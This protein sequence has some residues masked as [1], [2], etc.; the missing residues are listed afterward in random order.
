MTDGKRSFDVGDVLRMPHYPTVG[1]GRFRVWTVEGVHLGGTH[2]EGTYELRPIDILPNETIH[3]PCIM[4][5]MHPGVELVQSSP[6]R[7]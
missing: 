3:V 6:R 2:Q 4:L 7:M 5:E 1:G